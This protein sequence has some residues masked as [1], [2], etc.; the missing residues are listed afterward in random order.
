MRPSKVA[1]YVY[2]LLVFLT[3]AVAGGFAYRLSMNPVAAAPQPKPDEFR[4]KYQEEMRTRLSLDQKQMGE[5]A[6]IL[7]TT[8]NRVKEV[9]S[10]WE[11]EAKE[12]ARP[13][14][15]SIHEDQVRSINAILSEAQR[16]EYE[17]FRVERQKRRDHMQKSGIPPG[18]DD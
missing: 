1:T 4:L 17:K 10:R 7:D 15:K 13:E 16:A 9:K 14:M 12:K 3:G 2:V 18:D 5:L 8:R 6:A 11:R